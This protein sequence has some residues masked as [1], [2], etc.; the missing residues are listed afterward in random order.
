MFYITDTICAL[1]AFLTDLLS[2]APTDFRQN[3]EFYH[4]V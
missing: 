2:W 1:Y 4:M 3:P